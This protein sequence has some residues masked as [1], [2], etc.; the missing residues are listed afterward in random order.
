MSEDLFDILSGG[1]GGFG[2]SNILSHMFGGGGHRRSHKGE[3]TIQSLNVTLEDLYNGKTSKL[4][5]TKKCLCAACNGFTFIL[6]TL[7][8]F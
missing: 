3:N 4:Q 2:S 1:G 5:L 8:L 7:Q 6:C